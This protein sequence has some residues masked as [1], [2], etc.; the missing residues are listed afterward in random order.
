[1][2]S[3]RQ[4]LIQRARELN[5]SDLSVIELQERIREV[6]SEYLRLRR[7]LMYTVCS[8]T[9]IG[10]SAQ[11]H[12]KWCGLRS[13]QQTVSTDQSRFCCTTLTKIFEQKPLS[14]YTRPRGALKRNL[15]SGQPSRTLPD[16]VI[17]PQDEKKE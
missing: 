11:I 6:C 12:C 15:G 14:R 4:R 3:E 13:E 7:K 10:V 2:D 1:M 9:R 16:N 17:P 8:D 5:T